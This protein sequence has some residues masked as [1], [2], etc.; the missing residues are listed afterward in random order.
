[1]GQCLEILLLPCNFFSRLTIVLTNFLFLI[2]TSAGECYLI[3]CLTCL[4]SG[5][6]I[7]GSRNFFSTQ[8]MPLSLASSSSFLL[9]EYH[10]FPGVTFCWCPQVLL[11]H[12]HNPTLILSLSVMISDWNTLYLSSGLPEFE[13]LI[14]TYMPTFLSGTLTVWFFWKLISRSKRH[15]AVRVSGLSPSVNF[16]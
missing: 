7:R 9:P 6:L 13:S 4:G 10:L 15:L 2:N 16:W 8:W 5:V 12:I 1:M 11:G 14:Y 3:N